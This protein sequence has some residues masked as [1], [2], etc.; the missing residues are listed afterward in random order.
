VVDTR[1]AGVEEAGASPL[2]ERFRAGTFRPK[3]DCE[4]PRRLDIGPLGMAGPVGG[5]GS[6]PSGSPRIGQDETR[7]AQASSYCPRLP[8]YY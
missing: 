3:Q 2:L 1:I 6:R 5:S 8:R 4:E 7:S